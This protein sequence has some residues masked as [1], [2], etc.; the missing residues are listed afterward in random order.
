[1]HGK[2]PTKEGMGRVGDFDLGHLRCWVL[3]GGTKLWDRLIV[4]T[5]V[6]C[7]PNSIHFHHYGGQFADGS[8]PA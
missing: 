4:S 7:S 6:P 2:T 5:I 1:V 3:E 8:K